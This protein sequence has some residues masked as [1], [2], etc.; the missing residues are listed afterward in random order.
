M[1]EFIRL[2]AVDRAVRRIERWGTP[3]ERAALGEAI[4]VNGSQRQRRAIIAVM[5]RV[6][7]RR[8]NLPRAKDGKLRETPELRADRKMRRARGFW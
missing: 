8:A 3:E 4:S 2:S 5:E 6:D 7:Q 1:T